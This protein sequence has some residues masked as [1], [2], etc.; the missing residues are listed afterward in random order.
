MVERLKINQLYMST[1]A[2]KR[3]MKCDETFVR[4]HDLSSLRTIAVGMWNII[5]KL[6]YMQSSLNGVLEHVL[7]MQK[8]IFVGS[9]HLR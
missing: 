5:T 6:M 9:V 2:V 1:T 8:D 7:C 3:L 4:Q